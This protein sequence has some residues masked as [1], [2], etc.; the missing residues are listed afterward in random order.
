M[1]TSRLS[2]ILTC[3]SMLAVTACSSGGAK[4]STPPG[5]ESPPSAEAPKGEVP[6]SSNEKKTIVFST[7]WED[8][9]FE[10]AKRKYEAL[11]PNITIR[12]THVDTSNSTLEADLEKY[13][14]TTDTEM[15]A[16]K[17]PDLLQL[18]VLSPDNFVK[19][20]LLADMGEMMDRDSDFRKEDYFANILDNARVGGKLYSLPLSFFLIGFAGDT[21]AI[22]KTGVPVDD[23]SW[24]WNDFIVDAKQLAARGGHRPALVYSGPEYL[25]ANLVTDNYDSFVDAEGRKASFDSPAFLDAMKQV[26]TMFDEGVVSSQGREPAYFYNIQINSPWDYLV[27]LRERGEHMK[28]YE[29]PHAEGGAAGGYFKTYRAVGISANSKV[30]PEAWDFVKFMMSEEVQT[31][32]E[33]AGIPINMKVY[34]QQIQKLK[35]EGIV[36]AYEEGP[37]HG[38]AIKVDPAMLDQLQDFVN[39]AVHKIEYQSDKVV[40]MIVKESKAY[41]A[42]QKSAEEVAK[43]LQNKAMTY[44]NE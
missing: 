25:L 14:S 32:P 4:D 11:H 38:Q 33:T 8:A 37:L 40:K 34:A 41:F 23:K 42:G 15:L 44:L 19:R 2:I 24:S 13:V 22:A 27:S 36:K 35:S 21:D 30:K 16:G 17:G 31:P 20:K 7:F 28:L 5:G 18:D 9:R 12:L 10:E 43:L 6:P 26:K 3:L 39:G 1:R 29:K